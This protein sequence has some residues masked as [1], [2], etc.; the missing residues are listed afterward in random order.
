MQVDVFQGLALGARGVL[1]VHVVEVDG[2]VCHVGNGFGGIGDRGLGG[3]HLG[4]T[5]RRFV[6]HGHHDKNH[7]QLHQAHHNLEAVGKG[8]GQLAHVEQRALARD[9]ELGAQVDDDNER[10]VDANV[11]HG[12]VKG[13][14]L[15]GAGEVHLDVVRSGREFLLLVVLAHIALD[16]AHAG[17]VFLDGLVERVVFVEHAGK[18][19]TYLV[20]D[21]EQAK[22]Q[23][24]DD[25]QVDKRDAAAHGVGHDEGEDQHQRRAHG[26]ADEHH[27]GLLY[28]VDVGS[29]AGDERGARERV[30]IGETERLNLVE[31]VVTQVLG[32]AA[33]RMTA[34]DTGCGT[35]G[36]RRQRDEH[37]DAGGGQDVRNSGA[38]FDGVD[39]V[40]GDKRDA[41][42]ADDLAQYQ[43]RRGNSDFLVVTDACCKRFNHRVPPKCFE[44][45]QA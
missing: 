3:Q 21:K 35:K 19:R 33:A 15:L 2:A 13:K 32:K 34:G 29:E 1:E 6:G 40:C 41:H 39:K 25:D 23:Q 24:W 9:D 18:D 14:Q 43:Q 42:L 22:A 5:V 44:S 45:F 26:D 17:D 27:K 37:E 28:V 10:A 36:E 38:I 20:D 31:Q 4:N 11:H 30:D 7:R 12:V 16:H 8:R